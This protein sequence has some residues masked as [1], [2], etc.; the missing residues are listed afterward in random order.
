MSAD[1]ETVKKVLS[2]KAEEGETVIVNIDKDQAYT[3]SDWEIIYETEAFV[4]EREKKS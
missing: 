4:V 1:T 2:G 3:G